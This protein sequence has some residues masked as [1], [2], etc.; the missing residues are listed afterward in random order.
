MKTRKMKNQ[1]T[2]TRACLSHARATG[3]TLLEVL[4]TL[5]VFAVALL[6]ML[7]LQT[8]ALRVNQNALSRSVASQYAYAMLDILRSDWQT[9]RTNV[10]NTAL[11]GVD[12]ATLSAGS[13]TAQIVRQRW[14]KQLKRALPESKVQICRRSNARAQTATDPNVL[15][16]ASD[17]EVTPAAS[18]GMDYF[19]VRIDWEEAR[20][21]GA[22]NEPEA[23]RRE[24]FNSIKVV[25]YLPDLDN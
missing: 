15:T 4:V 12:S 17:C 19:V 18:N 2:K 20:A 21:P 8:S 5:V 14:V 10:Y 7:G 1:K 16:D 13:G 25:A 11:V 22:S 9:A 3:F 23:A 6:A 24:A